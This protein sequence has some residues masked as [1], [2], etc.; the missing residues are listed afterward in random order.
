[1]PNPLI[2]IGSAANDGTGE[3]GPRGWL[4]KLNRLPNPDKT[5]NAGSG[6]Y[7]GTTEQKIAAAVAAAGLLGTGASVWI[8]ASMVPYDVTQVPLN[9][10]VAMGREG[11]V[12]T[13]RA[14]VMAYGA[15]ADDGV[16]DDLPAFQGALNWAAAQVGGSGAIRRIT[17]YMPA[18]LYRVSGP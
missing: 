18:G 7:T 5:I 8:P 4:Q 14:D 11:H 10:A 16:H 2:N 13:D 15:Y 12:Q 9:T 17:V 3:L 1:M 6:D